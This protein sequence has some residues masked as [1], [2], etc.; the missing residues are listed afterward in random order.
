M[1]FRNVSKGVWK[2]KT[3]KG[4]DEMKEVAIKQVTERCACSIDVIQNR[5]YRQ[6]SREGPN[7]LPSGSS[8]VYSSVNGD[9]KKCDRNQACPT[10][11]DIMDEAL[12]MS[13]LE[14]IFCMNMLFIAIDKR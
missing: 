11:L 12:I 9:S 6:G 14:S 5:V 8:S 1:L 13:R 4:E 3:L 2:R 10:E 7:G